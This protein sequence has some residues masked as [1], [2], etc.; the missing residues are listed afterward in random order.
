M[1]DPGA[2][3]ATPSVHA[4]ALVGADLLSAPAGALRVEEAREVVVVLSRSRSPE[5]EVALDACRADGVP[6]LVRPSGG[7]AVVLA[8]GVVAASLLLA[9]DPATRFPEPYFRRLC[10]AVA[11]ALAACGVGGAAMRGISDLALGERKVA[12]SSLRLFAGKVLFQVSVLVDADVRLLERYLKPPSRQPDYRR[13]RSHREFV[14]TL[15]E[16][17][18]PVSPGQVV[19][20]VYRALAAEAARA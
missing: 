3:P 6:V 4:L 5:R 19:G 16:A 1:Q 18:Y 20:A 11:G 14:V 15:R 8:P 12:G 13:G 17:G 7:G 10:G 2:P 9:A